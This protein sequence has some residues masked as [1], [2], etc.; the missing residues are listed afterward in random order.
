MNLVIVIINWRIKTKFE[1]FGGN[2]VSGGGGCFKELC[3]SKAPSK[4]LAFS[5]TLDSHQGKS[6]KKTFI[7]SGEY[8]EACVL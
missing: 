2:L 1:D 3:K 6:L 8:E 5:W 4:V 7:G